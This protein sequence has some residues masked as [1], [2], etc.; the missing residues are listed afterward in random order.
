M[1]IKFL[2]VLSLATIAGLAGCKGSD[3]TNVNKMNANTNTNVA[4]MTP[5]APVKDTAVETAVKDALTKKGFTDVTVEGTA[6]EVTLR[7]TVAKGKMAELNQVAQETAK[8][9]VVNQ[10]TEK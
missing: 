7:G 8:R 4:V 5:A 10:V 3:N 9:K 2:A 6:T 1:K